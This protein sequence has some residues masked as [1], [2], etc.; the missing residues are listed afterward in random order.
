MTAP[1]RRR[2]RGCISRR[3]CW[4]RWS[5]AACSASRS[6]CMSAPAPSCRCGPTMWRGISMHAERGEITREAAATINAA[7]RV[8]AVGTTSLRLLE[9]AAEPDGRAAQPFCRRDVAVHRAGI[10]VS[11]CRFAADQLSPA[12][13]DTVHAGVRVRGK[14]A[15]ASGLRT[16]DRA[17][18]PVL[19]VWR[20][21]S[22]GT[23]GH[24]RSS[25]QGM[26]ARPDSFRLA[27][28]PTVLPGQA[29]CILCMAR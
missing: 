19:F 29:R 17:G 5:D 26:G 22:A 23:R 28:R 18:L 25:R 21:L 7:E 2:P 14:R 9:T 27:S 15:D 3:R 20:C 13:F 10:P 24:D 8:V 1:W 12:A 4:M 11:G 6:R 16:C